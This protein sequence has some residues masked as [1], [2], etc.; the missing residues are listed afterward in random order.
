[1]EIQKGGH[2]KIRVP[3]DRLPYYE[4]CRKARA[5]C[6]IIGGFDRHV[7]PT[8]AFLGEFHLAFGQ[9]KERMVLTHAHIVTRIIFRSALPDD[10][11]AREHRFAAE[12]FHTEPF[13][14][15]VAAI[16]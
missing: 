8:A 15:G 11:I 12:F 2:A 1:M 5:L 16:A 9:G 7:T 4:T 6:L 3:P 10:N 14:D 13:A